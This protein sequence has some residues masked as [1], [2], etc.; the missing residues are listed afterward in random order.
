MKTYG[1]RRRTKNALHVAPAN[2]LNRK[3]KFVEDLPDYGDEDSQAVEPWD[4]ETQY[5]ESRVEEEEQDE[6]EEQNTH[7]SDHDQ[8]NPESGHSSE[9]ETQPADDDFPFNRGM[10]PSTQPRNWSARK[11]VALE[12]PL[13]DRGNKVRVTES[14]GG[15]VAPSAMPKTVRFEGPMSSS[16]LVLSSEMSR[17]SPSQAPITPITPADVAHPPSTPDKYIVGVVPSTTPSYSPLTMK[18]DD[19][20]DSGVA[21]RLFDTDSGTKENEG[22]KEGGV[23]DDSRAT[24]SLTEIIQPETP[25]AGGHEQDGEEDHENHEDHEQEQDIEE[26]RNMVADSQW[27]DELLCSDAEEDAEED[28]Q[29]VPSSSQDQEVLM[30]PYSSMTGPSSEAASMPAPSSASSLHHSLDPEETV[31]E[32]PTGIRHVSFAKSTQ[33]ESQ[34]V[35]GETQY[36]PGESL[37]EP[38]EDSDEESDTQKPRR[39]DKEN[40]NSDNEDSDREENQEES[41]LPTHV[42]NASTIISD[43]QYCPYDE[44]LEDVNETNDVETSDELH[45]DGQGLDWTQSQSQRNKPIELSDSEEP[46]ASIDI[47]HDAHESLGDTRDDEPSQEAQTISDDEDEEVTQNP[48]TSMPQGTQA[49]GRQS[50]QIIPDS[51]DEESQERSPFKQ[52]QLKKPA[53]GLKRVKP[54]ESQ[55]PQ[56]ITESQLLMSGLFMD[57][58]PPDN[59]EDDEEEDIVIPVRRRNETPDDDEYVSDSQDE[60]D[61][62]PQPSLKREAFA[63]LPPLPLKPSITSSDMET[64]AF[65]GHSITD[66]LLEPLSDPDSLTQDE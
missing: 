29:V 20:V 34:Y 36:G 25:K 51:D 58:A 17:P 28:A 32:T 5:D 9:A 27:Q 50:M 64:Q 18:F 45:R 49:P 44:P 52:P 31:D 26:D 61:V 42:T 41:T 2:H 40:D 48:P 1:R 10:P 13:K 55:E 57:S 8:Y 54:T 43:S 16:P 62:F 24:E 23:F 38:D 11:R 19:S 59:D 7:L 3:H 35:P 22:D 6:Q 66:T 63:H 21:R 56:P 60:G 53:A 15:S 33:E 30:D 65:I 47:Y 46:V 37:Y 14:L 12:S 4:G 39:E